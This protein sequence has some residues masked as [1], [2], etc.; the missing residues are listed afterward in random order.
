MTMPEI[1]QSANQY[2]TAKA[3]VAEKREDQKRPQAKSSWGSL[4]GLP[5]KRTERAEQKRPK[6]QRDPKITARFENEYPGHDDA[7]VISAR[8]ANAHVKRIMIDTGS[9][10][11]ILYFDAFQ[12]LGI[13]LMT[14]T[15][16]GFTMDAI[17]PVG[18]TTLPM[19]FDEELRTKTLVISF[20]VVEL[21]SAYNMIIDRS[22]LNKLRAIVSTYHHSIKFP[23]NVGVGEVK[24]DP[25]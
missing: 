25:W 12:K 13:T 23:T 5:T 18:I 24:S 11:D 2:V 7:L 22:T 8:I 4:P 15:L 9:S 19:T 14:S 20:M 21:P 3:L 16:I 10:A 6:V 1:L 17:T